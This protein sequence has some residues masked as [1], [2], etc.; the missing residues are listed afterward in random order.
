M[1]TIFITG[2]SSGLGKAAVKLFAAKGWKVI[3]TMR[4]PEKEIELTDLENVTLLPLDVADPDQIKKVA[5]KAIDMGVDVVL[6]NAG[7][8]LG[9]PLE[10]YSDE[11]IQNQINTNLLGVIRV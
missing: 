8:G 4:T 7:Y 5:K 2:T 1:S 10:S 11:Q 6:N 3:A 9:G